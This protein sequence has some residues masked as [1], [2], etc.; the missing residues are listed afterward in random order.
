MLVRLGLRCV[1]CIELELV[2]ENFFRGDVLVG[3][4]GIVGKMLVL[5]ESR[6]LG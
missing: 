2:G 6:W 1:I 5:I 4:I 3:R